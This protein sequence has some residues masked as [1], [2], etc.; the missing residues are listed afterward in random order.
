[1]IPI[2]PRF[3]LVSC[4][5]ATQPT[6]TKLAPSRLYKYYRYF[7]PFLL[8]C[9]HGFSI[10]QDTVFI[11]SCRSSWTLS[12]FLV[13]MSSLP[14]RRT[15]II[16]R[17]AATATTKAPFR[18]NRCSVLPNESISD[19]PLDLGLTDDVIFTPVSAH[20]WHHWISAIGIDFV[21]P[22]K[23]YLGTDAPIEPKIVSHALQHLRKTFVKVS[24]SNKK[25]AVRLVVVELVGGLGISCEN[26]DFYCP[27]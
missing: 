2:K 12:N 4:T 13:S 8:N 6:H 19:S 26:E 15:P 1:M 5:V 25:L 3:T 16:T 27:E 22:E 23:V 18:D 20:K 14:C 10:P 24:S 17:A 21:R 11:C 9:L 7:S